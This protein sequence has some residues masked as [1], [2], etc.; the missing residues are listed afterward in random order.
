MLLH[1]AGM[2]SNTLS[3]IQQRG[4][5]VE[6]SK[7]DIW[8]MQRTAQERPDVQYQLLAIDFLPAEV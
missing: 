1:Y 8:S 6:I 5:L 2:L 4:R 7:R 3:C